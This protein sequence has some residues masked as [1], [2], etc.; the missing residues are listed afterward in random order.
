MAR[1]PSSP[2]C[3]CVHSQSLR[4][5]ADA[6]HPA[7]QARLQRP[8][9]WNDI[10]LDYCRGWPYSLQ[11]GFHVSL[12][13]CSRLP[14]NLPVAAV[15]SLSPPGQVLCSSRPLQVQCLTDA[16]GP[17]IHD[18]SLQIRIF[19]KRSSSGVRCVLVPLKQASCPSGESTVHCCHVQLRW[20]GAANI[21]HCLRLHTCLG[22]GLPQ[23]TFAV[24]KDSLACLLQCL[25]MQSRCSLRPAAAAAIML[26]QPAGVQAPA[27]QTWLCD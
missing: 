13:S 19:S 4:L 9:L 16:G 27:M 11:L 26:E 2:A 10:M 17:H 23:S 24:V 8:E 18:P 22:F 6:L 3:R 12:D 7:L 1:H 14:R 5:F 15:F 20:R 21:A 25:S